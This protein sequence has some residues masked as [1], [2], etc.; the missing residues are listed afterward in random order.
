MTPDDM[1]ALLSEV[2]GAL[3]GAVT[4]KRVADAPTPVVFFQ[5]TS[6][7][8]SFL[9]AAYALPPARDRSIHLGGSSYSG[10][11]VKGTIVLRLPSAL[12]ERGYKL[13]AEKVPPT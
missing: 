11:A 5:G 13:A 3:A 6:S 9:V 10:T 2:E 4:W 7:T 12:A 1:R 8:W